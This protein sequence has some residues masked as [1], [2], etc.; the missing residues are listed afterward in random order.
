[1]EHKHFERPTTHKPENVLARRLLYLILV[2]VT[3]LIAGGFGFA[4]LIRLYEPA[5]RYNLLPESAQLPRRTP[6]VQLDQ[7]IV[8]EAQSIASSLVLFLKH[9]ASRT[10]PADT[11]VDLSEVISH[12]VVLTSDGWLLG[13]IP[14]SFSGPLDAFID[15]EFYPISRTVRDSFTSVT[16]SRI[17]A[18]DLSPVQVSESLPLG[19]EFIFSSSASIGGGY[20]VATNHVSNPRWTPMNSK[21][22]AVKS[23]TQLS[24]FIQL[25]Q[26]SSN[27]VVFRSDGALLGL[28]RADDDTGVIPA[29]QIK[30]SF[31]QLLRGDT[32]VDPGIY[33]VDTTL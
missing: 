33:Y 17:A 27:G 30:I 29:R 5:V 31:E 8:N 32:D 14:S 3:G 22:D 6:S 1:M 4:L 28:T 16:F 23:G 13:Q 7:P 15:G 20:R 24:E 2:A 19:G 25:D 12:G 21:Y 9:R 26:S 10:S 11:L 18:N